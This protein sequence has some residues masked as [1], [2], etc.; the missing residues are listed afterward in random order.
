MNINNNIQLLDA[1]IKMIINNNI[2]L[3]HITIKK[4]INNIQLL[5]I[6]IKNGIIIL[7]YII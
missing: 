2:E 6:I 5:D 7:T 1:V 4:N 3:F